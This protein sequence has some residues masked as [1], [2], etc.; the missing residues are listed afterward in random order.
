MDFYDFEDFI[1]GYWDN[2]DLFLPGYGE[3]LSGSRREW[4]YDK[5][6]KKMDRDGIKKENYRLLLKLAKEGCNRPP[7]P[8]RR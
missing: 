6:V 1:S 4:K 2:Y 3:V 5:L 7:R 8:H